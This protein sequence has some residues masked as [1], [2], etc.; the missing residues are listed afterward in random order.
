LLLHTFSLS[1]GVYSSRFS[2][3]SVHDL[4][5]ENHV[6]AHCAN[7]IEFSVREVPPRLKPGASTRAYPCGP[8][9]GLDAKC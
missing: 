7:V 9:P 6:L 5:G 2:L 4:A 3:K 1:F 8:L